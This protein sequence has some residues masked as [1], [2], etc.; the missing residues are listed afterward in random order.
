MLQHACKGE[1]HEEREQQHDD[2]AALYRQAE[3]L[4]ARRPGARVRRAPNRKHQRCSC[5]QAA[6][7]RPDQ[8]S[9]W[10]PRSARVCQQVHRCAHRHHHGQRRDAS[11]DQASAEASV[12][13]SNQHGW[14]PQVQP[15][16]EVMHA[17]VHLELD[18]QCGCE[19][20]SADEEGQGREAAIEE[21][22]G[23]A[24]C[25]PAKRALLELGKPA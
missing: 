16:P 4:A 14:C 10:T 9:L 12:A 15:E 20:G 13:G 1:D 2:W 11:E 17:H 18:Q 7:Q 19:E 8:L 6:G 23:H 24:G 5:Q 21:R 22:T 3:F 25:T